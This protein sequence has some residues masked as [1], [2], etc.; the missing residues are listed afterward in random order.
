MKC[1]L[2]P[3]QIE[4]MRRADD[5]LVI[6]QTGVG[7]GKSRAL[8]WWCIYQAKKGRRILAVAQNYRALSEVLFREIE[9][10]CAQIGVEFDTNKSAKTIAI[11][12]GCIYGATGDNP[13]GILGFTD[14]NAAVFDEA[15]YLTR[16][17]YDFVCDRLRGDS[18]DVPLYRFTSSPSNIPASRWFRDLCEN[19]RDCVIRATSLDNA[20]TSK[21]YKRDLQKR[22]GIGTALYRQQVLGEFLETDLEDT[23]FGYELLRAAQANHPQVL[24][25]Y[26]DELAVIGVDCARYGGDYTVAVLRIGRRIVKVLRAR[27]TDT[28]QIV[29]MVRRLKDICEQNYYVRLD[30]VCVDA[31]YGNG[32]I[33][34]LRQL[35]YNVYEVYFGERAMANSEYFNNRAEMYYSA[36]DWLNQGGTFLDEELAADLSAQRYI[37]DDGGK[38]RLVPKELIKKVLERSPDTSDAFVLTFYAAAVGRDFNKKVTLDSMDQVRRRREYELEE[39]EHSFNFD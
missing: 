23:V 36:K 34:M 7:A 26:Q 32:A 21:Q 8:A 5:P 35:N 13:K 9:I 27:S 6:L 30:A 25:C 37:L 14:F 22:Y 24:T 39:S 2:S 16:E 1:Q 4:F 18:V 10:V 28:G 15:A 11:G 3:F 38:F 31:A 12:N 17:V 33:D 19:N 29:A 20:F